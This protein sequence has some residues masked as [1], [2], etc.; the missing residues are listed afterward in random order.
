MTVDIVGVPGRQ[1]EL[2]GQT[3][4]QTAVK[5]DKS[6]RRMGRAATFELAQSIQQGSARGFKRRL[7]GCSQH[8][9]RRLHADRPLQHQDLAVLELEI[10]ELDRILDQGS[11]LLVEFRR[12]AIA[13]QNQD[14]SIGSYSSQRVDRRIVK[15]EVHNIGN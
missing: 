11:K 15:T 4:C 1:H 9:A 3:G 14:Q 2:L 13:G 7:A 8:Q 6:H 5:A 12:Q 10:T